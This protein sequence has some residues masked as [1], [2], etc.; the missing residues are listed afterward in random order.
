[1]SR[2][3]APAL[4]RI[5]PAPEQKRSLPML[6]WYPS[7]FMSSTRGWSVTARGVYRELL[8]VQWEMGALPSEAETLQRIIVATNAEWKSWRLIEGKF[9]IGTDGLRRNPRLEKEHANA[10]RRSEKASDSAR[11]KWRQERV[12][13]EREKLSKFG[14]GTDANA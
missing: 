10:I 1:M 4:A 8:D 11:E 6:P 12:R 3:L 7:S 5:S 9:P 14:G 13:I 2:P